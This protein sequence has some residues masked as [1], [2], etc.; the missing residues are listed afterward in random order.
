M[1]AG[2][3][4]EIRNPLGGI[5][6]FATLL[7][8]ELAEDDPRREHLRR[9]IRE[10]HHL[11]TIVNEFLVYA[12]P[13]QPVPEAFAVA[14]VLEDLRFLI[15]GELAEK[16]VELELRLADPGLRV[17]ADADQ[18][19]RAL[20][21]LVRNAIHASPPRRAIEVAARRAGG[22]RARI[23]VVDHGS[24]ISAEDLPFVFDPFFT[25][26]GTGV[27]L[28]LSIVKSIVDENDGAIAVES[29]PGRGTA[30]SI[31]LPEAGGAGERPRRPAAAPAAAASGAGAGAG[32]HG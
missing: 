7:R 9:I 5:E 16:E 26:K 32:I 28:G 18:V 12:R 21:N 25:T 30:F 14:P 23:D 11:K 6:I 15:A 19:K 8:D 3:A 20:L 1:L 31:V 13:R 10:V 24:G 29:A 17:L 2:V 22:G 4:H 27:G